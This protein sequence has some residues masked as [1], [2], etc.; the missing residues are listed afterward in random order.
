MVDDLLL[1]KNPFGQAHWSVA[2]NPLYC[3]LPPHILESIIK[4]GTQRQRERALEHLGINHSLHVARVGFDESLRQQRQA[5]RQQRL[6]LGKSRFEVALGGQK[7]RT[8]YTANNSFK[9]PGTPVRSEGAPPT[10]DLAVDE[11]YTYMGNTYD[12][13]WNIFTRNSIDDAGMRLDGSVHYSKDYDNAF[14]DGQRMIYG[15]GDQEQFNRFTIAVDI[16]GHE[17]THGVTQNEAGLIYFSQPGAM[18]ESL[19]DVFG[20]LVKQYVNNQRADQADWLIG[21]GLFTPN[22][23]GVA[24]RSM[25]DPGTAYG[26]PLPDP[27]LGTDPQPA[28]MQKSKDPRGRGYQ[29]TIQD[30]GGVHINSGIPN[31][32]FYLASIYIGGYAWEKAGLIWYETLRSTALKPGANFRTFAQLTVSTG[33]RLFGGN[34]VE[35]QAVRQGWAEVGIVV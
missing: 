12:F 25:K 14:W 8:I 17:L 26:Y 7:E 15:D 21:Q 11:A 33:A 16:I 32:A 2:R 3:I 24:I 23:R 18:N 10:G 22:V 29:K 5:L 28:H 4:R 31:R 1:D 27:V 34:S 19:S 6:A 9:V 20:S 30:S 35:L 13:Y